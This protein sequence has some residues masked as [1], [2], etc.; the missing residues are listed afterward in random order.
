VAYLD[1]IELMTETETRLLTKEEHQLIEWMLK[2]GSPEALQFLPQLASAR[3]T[4][5]R[6]PCGCASINFV[7]EG[8]PLAE[9]RGIYVIADFVFGPADQLSGIFVFQKAGMLAGLEVYGLAGD[10]PKH[11]PAQEALRPF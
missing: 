7:L 9:S 10:A 3:A 2:H 4:S 6:C 8:Q 1:T 11:L 5:W